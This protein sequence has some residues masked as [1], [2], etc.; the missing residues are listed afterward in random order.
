MKMSIVNKILLKYEPNASHIIWQNAEDSFFAIF[1]VFI[2]AWIEWENLGEE[3]S[4]TENP[5]QAIHWIV[6]HWLWVSSFY[7]LFV[8]RLQHQKQQKE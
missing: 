5:I 1:G 6:S 4:K 3:P 2:K 8:F 7:Y